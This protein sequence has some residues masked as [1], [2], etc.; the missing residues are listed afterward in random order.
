M[1]NWTTADI[2]A[3]R[4][5]IAVV[6]GTGGIGFEV[7]LALSRAGAEIILA[8]R[9]PTKGAEAVAAIHQVVPSARVRFEAVDLASLASVAAFADRIAGQT[10]RLDLLVNN[11]GVMRPPRR[12]TTDDGFEIQ[13][14]VNYLSHFALT[15]RLLPLLLKGEGARVVT[16]SSVAARQGAINFDDLQAERAYR[17]MHVYAQSKLAC[18]MFAFELQRRAEANGWPLSSLAAHPGLSKTSLLENAP[19]GGGRVAPIYRMVRALLM[20]T[21]A[22]GALPALYAATA[23]QASPGG[24]YGP[25]RAGETRGHPAPSRIPT[26]ARDFAAARLLWEVSEDL[27]GVR[28]G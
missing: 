27:T 15:G 22:Q 20:Q 18:L 8:G 7:A 6:T 26:A 23:A 25:D 16:L 24:Y 4:G 10:D 14:G 12:M 9:N 3:Q 1:T 28:Y 13:L 17:S 19:G 5:R 21:P 2:P 11:A